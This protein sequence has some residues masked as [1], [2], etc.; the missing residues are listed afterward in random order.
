MAAARF[1]E[2]TWARQVL[3]VAEGRAGGHSVRHLR[4]PVAGDAHNRGRQVSE[5]QLPPT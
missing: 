3:A 2:R 5:P 1:A 4:H